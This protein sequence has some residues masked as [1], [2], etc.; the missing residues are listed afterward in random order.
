M[1]NKLNITTVFFILDKI[2][3]EGL[4]ITLLDQQIDDDEDDDIAYNKNETQ[5][6]NNSTNITIN[7]TLVKTEE[8]RQIEDEIHEREGNL[9]FKK[10]KNRVLASRPQANLMKMD[11]KKWAKLSALIYIQIFS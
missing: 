9:S 8:E 2:S 10:A 5:N 11:M 6:D 1:Y 7:A 3:L 4:N